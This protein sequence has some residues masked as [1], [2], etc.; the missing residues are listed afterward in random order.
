MSTTLD[1]PLTIT[2]TRQYHGLQASTRLSL[3]TITTDHY[4]DGTPQ[5]AERILEITTS[6]R[7]SGGIASTAH[8]YLEAGNTKT[9]AIFGDYRSARL[10]PKNHLRATEKNIRLIHA[11]AL[12]QAERLV[13]EAHAFYARKAVPE[14]TF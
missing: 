5:P 1:Q 2:I 8:V 11:E 10:T 14:I 12:Q 7:E 6:K 13:E 3:G 9:F 4:S